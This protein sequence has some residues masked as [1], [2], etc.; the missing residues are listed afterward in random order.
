MFVID[1]Q[2]HGGG[3]FDRVVRYFLQAPIYSVRHA[4]KYGI[5]HLIH[6]DEVVFLVVFF[7]VLG[8]AIWWSRRKRVVP[9]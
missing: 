7:V 1:P 5:E 6:V 8:G 3:G 9:A 4:P 2:G